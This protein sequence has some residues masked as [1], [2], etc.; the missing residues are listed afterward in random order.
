L[1]CKKD[2]ILTNEKGFKVNESGFQEKP[3]GKVWFVRE[4]LR[5][6]MPLEISPIPCYI[7]AD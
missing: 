1:S 5:P 6:L 2:V 3:S 7:I 4:K